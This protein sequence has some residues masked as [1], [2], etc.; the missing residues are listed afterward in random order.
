M[1][2]SLSILSAPVEPF[3]YKPGEYIVYPGQ[4]LCVVSGYSHLEVA[5]AVTP[6]MQC[7]LLKNL[8]TVISKPQAWVVRSGMRP[9]SSPAELAKIFEVFE[10]RA[11]TSGKMWARKKEDYEAAFATGDITAIAG[12]IHSILHKHKDKAFE[13]QL[14]MQELPHLEIS[15][16]ERLL[17]SKSVDFLAEEINHVTGCAV[18]KAQELLHASALVP[19]Y[20]GKVALPV[21]KK[22]LI[23]MDEK[24]FGAAFGLSLAQAADLTDP[25]RTIS[26]QFRAAAP[27]PLRRPPSPLYLVNPAAMP[28][29]FD[30]K[31]KPAASKPVRPKREVK[32]RAEADKP[33][34]RKRRA[35]APPQ[36]DRKPKLIGGTTHSKPERPAFEKKEITPSVAIAREKKTENLSPL[37]AS[38]RAMVPFKGFMVTIAKA[39]GEVLTPEEFGIFVPVKIRSTA[40]RLTIGQAAE[41]Q[42]VSEDQ[43]FALHDLAGAKLRAHLGAQ[44][45]AAAR[46]KIF[47]PL[48]RERAPAPKPQR[49]P[50]PEK[51][52]APRQAKAK[53]EFLCPSHALAEMPLVAAK[54]PSFYFRIASTLLDAD[55]LDVI[56]K[57]RLRLSTRRMS[58]AKIATAK[59]MPVNAVVDLFNAGAEKM[60]AALP[61]PASAKSPANM[62]RPADYPVEEPPRPVKPEKAERP[63]KPEK[64]V[65]K[66]EIAAPKA[67]RPGSSAANADR[68]K[69]SVSSLANTR[70]AIQAV[71]QRENMLVPQSG[72]CRALFKR[73]SE[74]LPPEQFA[75]LT[76]HSLRRREFRAEVPALSALMRRPEK[77]IEGMIASARKTLGM[78]AAPAASQAK[79]PVIAPGNQAV[80]ARELPLISH[81]SM[82]SIFQRAA[83]ILTTQEFDIFSRARLRNRLIEPVHQQARQKGMPKARLLSI[84]DGAADKLRQSFAAEGSNLARFRALERHG[85][86]ALPNPAPKRG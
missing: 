64:P 48:K 16:S 69:P 9:P 78:A 26:V 77:E 66:P 79:E 8:R 44:K 86:E 27:A 7:S 51:T 41:R 70:K 10:G 40:H 25:G 67:N 36:P 11:A 13:K 63:A 32:E 58:F 74:E 34:A 24:S 18:A 53:P 83:E 6:V 43:A 57:S 20:A 73:A 56:A 38:E 72:V 52:R 31:P 54:V 30:P 35:A 84:F 21:R 61:P 29:N 2:S 22:P 49:E 62:F 39:A 46:L 5:G 60:R 59:D 14:P 71:V 81:G 4:G 68:D 3:S 50:K 37:F 42:A 47:D 80:Y 23:A 55:E 28:S 19:G 65:K 17:V 15:Y 45:N 82:R 76:A 85:A 1:S 75:L 33:A 12:V